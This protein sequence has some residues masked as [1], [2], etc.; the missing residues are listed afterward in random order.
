MAIESFE[1][2]KMGICIDL[3]LIAF[4]SLALIVSLW[5]S[6]TLREGDW[7]QRSG[8]IVVLISVLLEIRQSIAKQPQANSKL[9]AGGNPVMTKQHIPT[10]RN[11]FHWIAWSGIV[12]GT[13]IWGY[14]DLFFE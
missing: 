13:L 10:V 1:K 11:L 14:G 4:E 12:I 8:A 5:S 6:V 3:A 2:K 9:S 7:F